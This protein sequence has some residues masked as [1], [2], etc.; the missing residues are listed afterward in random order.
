RA[1][2]RVLLAG[3]YLVP[4]FHIPYHRIAYWNRFSRPQQPPLYYS[5][6]EWLW[7]WWLKEG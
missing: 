5:P 1:L 6:N 7:G 4:N 3:H 2:D